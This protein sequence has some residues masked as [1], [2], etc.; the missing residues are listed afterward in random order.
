M[1]KIV[2]VTEVAGEGLVALLG[3]RVTLFCLNY[4]YT[5][6]LAGVNETCCILED[7][8]IVYETGAFSDPKWKDVQALPHPVYVM[9]RCV[10]S[11]MLLK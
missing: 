11:F 3:Q 2:E 10:E 6:K 5:G 8:A 7:A 9:L 4:I 1:K